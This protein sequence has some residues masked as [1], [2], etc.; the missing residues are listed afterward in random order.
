MLFLDKWKPSAFLLAAPNPQAA[1]EIKELLLSRY[2]NFLKAWRHSLDTDSSNHCKFDEFVAQCKKLGYSGDAPGAWRHLDSDLSGYITLHEIDP[3]SSDDLQAF[4][5]WCDEE[6]GGVRS[7][8][9]VFDLSGDGDVTYREFRRSC[10]IYGFEG[11]VHHLFHALDVEKNGTVSA[12]EVSFL[13][14]WDF[15]D[16]EARGYSSEMSRQRMSSHVP[17]PT[18]RAAHLP[19]YMSEGPGPAAYV[20]QQGFGAGPIVPQTHFSGAYTFRKRLQVTQLPNIRRDAGLIPAPSHYDDRQGM[21]AISPTK[22]SWAFPSQ[23][24][25]SNET[26]VADTDPG[27]GS[28][29]P[30][31]SRGLGPAVSCT[32]R[33][34]L[35]VHPLVIGSPR[36]PPSGFGDLRAASNRG[37]TAFLTGLA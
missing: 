4:K 17:S 21:C 28:Y 33:R 23:R 1:T 2:K 3:V 9:T 31:R 37:P 20:A 19:D 11:K 8:F 25:A 12:E 18:Y 35:R 24:R 32:P 7:A 22:P 36:G 29:S 14:D 16:P 13:D 10:R 34:V 5:A 6:F 15:E 26:P 30:L 27:P